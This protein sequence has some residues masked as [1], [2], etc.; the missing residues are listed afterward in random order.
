MKVDDLVIFMN[1]ES[2]YAEWFY[3]QMGVIESV[4]YDK[5]RILRCRV[6]WLQPVKYINGFSL[7]SDFPASDFEVCREKG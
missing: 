1:R 4:S 6:S 7:Y 5:H 2:R 3:G